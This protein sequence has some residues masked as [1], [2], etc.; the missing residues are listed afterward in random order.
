MTN[1]S[2]TRAGY[3]YPG[4]QSICIEF[5]EEEEQRC[6][7]GEYAEREGQNTLKHPSSWRRR[8]VAIIQL[9]PAHNAQGSA[10]IVLPERIQPQGFIR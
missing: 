10:R 6:H 2:T 7:L 5:L 8:I 3:G 1:Q 4:Q 9:Y